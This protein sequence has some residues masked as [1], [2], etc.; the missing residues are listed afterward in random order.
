LAIQ[1]DLATAA[2]AGTTTRTV[3]IRSLETLFKS[4][5]DA[6]SLLGLV[7]GLEELAGIE[8]EH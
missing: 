5:L 2:V 7:T 3:A 1:N 6:R 8:I 4:E